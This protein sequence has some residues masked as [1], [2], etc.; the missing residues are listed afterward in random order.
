MPLHRFTNP[1]LQKCFLVSC[2]MQIYI[3]NLWSSPNYCSSSRRGIT[4]MYTFARG[5][6][7]NIAFLSCKLSFSFLFPLFKMSYLWHIC[8]LYTNF[9]L[10][11]TRLTHIYISIN[12]SNHSSIHPGM[13]QSIAWSFP[14]SPNNSMNSLVT[15]LVRWSSRTSCVSCSSFCSSLASLRGNYLKNRNCNGQF[16][17][18]LSTE[19]MLVTQ[20]LCTEYFRRFSKFTEPL[21]TPAKI[22][23]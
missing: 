10:W 3:L 23:I 13:N 17:R 16:H 1:L 12:L 4:F 7:G 19:D 21:L 18:C 22:G 11:R 20:H 9:L 2:M 14:N 6:R 8:F 5:G 15:V